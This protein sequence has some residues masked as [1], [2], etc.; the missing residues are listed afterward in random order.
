MPST[1]RFH[2][3]RASHM[4]TRHGTGK[5]TEC[6]GGGSQSLQRHSGRRHIA[7]LPKGMVGLCPVSSLPGVLAPGR[8]LIVRGWPFLVAI[9]ALHG[10]DT[11]V[12]S[13]TWP[14]ADGLRRPSRCCAAALLHAGVPG[15]K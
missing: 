15:Q 13:S 14:H 8:S 9:P 10:A 4:G 1:T 2:H 7:P 5:S 11:L 6:R 12:G 3:P